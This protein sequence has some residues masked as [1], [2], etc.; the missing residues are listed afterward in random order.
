MATT[1]AELVARLSADVSD[2]KRGMSDAERSVVGQQNALRNL[3]SS[4]QDVGR[5]MSLYVSLPLAAIAAVGMKE[6][7]E[8]G[9]QAAITAAHIKSTGGAANVT[10]KHVDDLALSL[11]RL[12]GTDDEVIKS[13]ENMLLTFKGVRNEAGKGND[14][15]DRATKAALDLS[16]QFGSVDGA[17]KMLGKALADPVAGLTA[18]K[19]AGVNFSESQKDTIKYMVAAGD[20]LG[21]QRLILQEV[22]SQVGGT[23]KAYGQTMA[24][25]VA[26]ARQEFANAAGELMG[27]LAPAMRTIADLVTDISEAFMDMPDWAQTGVLL[28]GVFLA[29]AGPATTL[30]GTILKIKGALTGGGLAALAGQAAPAAAAP[31]M[32]A[33]G[34]GAAASAAGMTGMAASATA[35]GVGLLSVVGVGVE[36]YAIIDSLGDVSSGADADMKALASGGVEQNKTAFKDLIDI[37]NQTVQG[38]QHAA[39]STVGFHGSINDIN[40]VLGLTKTQFEQLAPQAGGYAGQVDLMR[41][42]NEALAIQ[43]GDLADKNAALAVKFIESATAAGVSGVGIDMMKAALDRSKVAH[44]DVT[45]AQQRQAYG[46]MV[47]DGTLRQFGNS[48]IDT[49]GKVIGYAT[50]FG[51]IPA[52][53]QTHIAVSGVAEANAALDVYRARI[54]ALPAEKILLVKAQLASIGGGA[55]GGVVGMDGRVYSRASGGPVGGM[56]WVGERGPELVSLPAGSRVH[57]N[58]NSMRMTGGGGDT[59]VSVHVGGSVV[60]ERDLIDAVQE[61]MARN[62]RRGRSSTN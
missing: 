59:Y 47:F 50:S 52:A 27:A 1:V 15:F 6:L 38:F 8:S 25:Q 62:T 12:S 26:I 55:T 19:R 60:T 17:A 39:E 58:Q 40:D 18:L 21:A 48:V 28:G 16:Y 10:A 35:L 41:Q 34:E 51:F 20:T 5:K 22:E 31:A 4:M 23:A 13:G 9:K 57:N 33:L 14:I 29:A 30:L 45:S 53:K 36:A 61:G 43:T 32:P 49:T 24:G 46:Q 56:T 42:R 2:F 7:A 44:D 11:M 3:G 37:Q 54:M